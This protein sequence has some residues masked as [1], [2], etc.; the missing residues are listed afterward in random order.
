MDAPFAEMAIIGRRFEAVT[1]E[2]L[3]EASQERAQ[4]RRRCG[5][6][7]GTGPCTRTTGDICAGAQ[8]GLADAPNCALL[9]GIREYRH[10]GTFAHPGGLLLHV[11]REAANLILGL[12]AE[13]HEQKRASL[14][15]HLHSFDA[16]RPSDIR[17]MMVEA[18]ERL[19]PM[20]E[21]PRH[22][23]AGE[24]DVVEAH[25]DEPELPGQWHELDGGI[26]D[27][28]ECAL[29]SNDGAREVEPVFRQQFVE[30]VT[31]NAPGNLRVAFA[32]RWGITL[33]ERAH[34]A[35]KLGGAASLRGRGRVL[36][37]A[38]TI[39][40]QAGTVVEHDIGAGH[41]IDRL[42]VGSRMRSA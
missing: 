35:V 30:V 33:R 13:F 1:I 8:A 10:A 23:I 31:R 32:N 27:D 25:H 40:R 16:L 17:Q 34:F 24:K 38:P 39:Q 29:R 26:E 9:G 21:H 4:P 36:A 7:L 12:A 37:F 3:H 5:A 18:L 19:R 20:R 42:A 2:E 11:F 28:R 41:V 22:L 6:I 14:G 15:K